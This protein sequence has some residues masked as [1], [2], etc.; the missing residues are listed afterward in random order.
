MA[1]QDKRLTFTE[2]QA[3]TA[4]AALADV[5]DLRQDRDLGPGQP[6]LY[7]VVQALVASDRTTGD[8]TY[9]FTLQTDDN[10]SFSSPTVVDTITFPAAVV[11]AGSV[12][13]HPLPANVG[14]NERYLRVSATLG[15]TTPSV[16]VASHLTNQHPQ[17]WQAMPAPTQA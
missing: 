6:P 2:S 10:P 5:V 16:T 8:E 12:F 13:A 15:G 4:S 7:W 1:V 3:L 11:A 14:S 17:A 9:S